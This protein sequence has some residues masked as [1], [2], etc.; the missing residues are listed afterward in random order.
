MTIRDGGRGVT[1]GADQP[2][3]VRPNLQY[4]PANEACR[5]VRALG[6][7]PPD[8]SGSSLQ[9]GTSL[10]ADLFAWHELN[11]TLITSRGR[12]LGLTEPKRLQFG[13]GKIIQTEQK[14]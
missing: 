3:G 13:L 11:K 4:I 5:Y 14:L 12:T 2:A 8:E 9:Q 10:T 7:A 1:R 6:Q